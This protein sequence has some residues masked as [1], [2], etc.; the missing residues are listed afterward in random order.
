MPFSSFFFFFIIFQLIRLHERLTQTD[1]SLIELCVRYT[2]LDERQHVLRVLSHRMITTQHR[3]F[4][5]YPESHIEAI[6]SS[7]RITYRSDQCQTYQR[8]EVDIVGIFDK[9]I[10]YVMHSVFDCNQ[11]TC[12]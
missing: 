12:M 6:E 10:R 1:D 3:Q 4:V 9:S 11:A 8:L 2:F 5:R 7:D